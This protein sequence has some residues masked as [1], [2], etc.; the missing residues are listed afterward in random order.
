M[1]AGA[2]I[3]ASCEHTGSCTEPSGRYSETALHKTPFDRRRSTST[4]QAVTA[5]ASA[6]VLIISHRANETAAMQDALSGFGYAVFAA[7]E[8]TSALSWI[9]SNAP[10]VILLNAR[11]PG[12]RACGI[13]RALKSKPATQHVP[14][15][16][17]N[18]AAQTT[19]VISAFDAGGA[20][21]INHGAPEGEVAARVAAHLQRSRLVKQASGALDAF[22]RATASICLN[23][24]HILWQT[25]RARELMEKFSA[26]ADDRIPAALLNWLARAVN[27]RSQGGEALPYTLTQDTSRL[28][29]T[30]LYRIEEGEW[31]VLLRHESETVLIDKFQHSL[32]L[33]PRQSEVLYWVSKG[34]TNREIGDI[35]GASPRT[36]NKHLEHVFTKLGVE[37]RTAAANLAMS[38]IAA[39]Y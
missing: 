37:T 8:M 11:M 38:S 29:F 18:G 35:L 39:R 6:C 21:Y 23:D 4:C 7:S 28:T 25:P 22:G 17:V 36:V 19:H 2:L 24:G 10:D 5:K 31:L 20:D 30:L 27:A 1:D 9:A 3:R 33:T 12:A 14:V 13:C 15:I 16:F 26:V 32:Q 34:K